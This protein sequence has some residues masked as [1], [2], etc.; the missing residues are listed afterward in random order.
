MSIFEIDTGRVIFPGAPI[1][2]GTV[3]AL[4]WSPDGKQLASASR[5]CTIRLTSRP[6]SGSA[7]EE[8]QRAPAVFAGYVKSF[9]ALAWTRL[10]GA[11]GDS[12]TAIFSAATDGAIRAWLPRVE[13]EAYPLDGWVAAAHWSPDDRW[14]AAV[15]F[16]WVVHIIDPASG[17]QYPLWPA[18]MGLHDVR[19]SPSGDRV[20]MCGR[21][22]GQVEIMDPVTGKTLAQFSLPGADRVAWS[23]SGEFLAASSRGA[24]WNGA[25]PGVHVWNTASGKEISY[26]PRRASSLLWSRNGRRLLVGQNDGSISD[27][28]VPA[29]ASPRVLRPATPS[30][31]GSVPS[32]VDPPEMVCDLAYSPDEKRLAFVTYDGTAAILDAGD[33]KVVRRLAESLP[34]LCCVTWSPDARRIAI[35]GKDDLLRIYSPEDG[36][37]MLQI[38]HGSPT[39]DKEI[40][41]LEWSRDGLRILTGGHDGVIRVWNAGRGMQVDAVEAPST[42]SPR[43]RDPSETPNLEKTYARLGWVDRARDA[44]KSALRRAPNP[45]VVAREAAASE[46]WFSKALSFSDPLERY[47]DPSLQAN[48][49]IISSLQ[50][51]STAWKRNLDFKSFIDAD[52]ETLETAVKNYRELSV[53][54]QA[55]ARLPLARRYFSRAGW[56]VTWFPARAEAF[57]DEAAWRGLAEGP[58]AIKVRGL[59][60][61]TFPYHGQGPRALGLDPELTAHGPEAANWGMLATTKINLPPGKWR[62]Q[63]EGDGAARVLL[64]DAVLIDAAAGSAPAVYFGDYE[65]AER[66]LISIVVEQSVATPSSGFEFLLFPILEK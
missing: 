65:Q 16:Y 63:V 58:G 49:Q 19:W 10:P 45:S 55:A 31:V 12:N 37:K 36:G 2:R 9:N 46:E 30:L 50:A 66:K 44:Y 47:M 22:S 24:P 23:A 21:E 60:R 14:L 61:V 8:Q 3:N 11:D 59:Q 64:D 48:R 62:F 40:Q 6:L 4:A 56:A 1:H 28:D 39:G 26:I 51:I 29:G 5:D 27:W 35:S 41:G 54:P 34:P 17:L 42:S 57:K 33:G 20:A 52:W 15:D 32:E 18:N 13:A 43:F 53:L 38:L 25:P 7:G